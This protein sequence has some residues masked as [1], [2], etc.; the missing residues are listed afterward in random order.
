MPLSQQNFQPS[1]GTSKSVSDPRSLDEL[2][3]FMEKTIED[4]DK[5]REE[6]KEQNKK[7]VELEEQNKKVVEEVQALKKAIEDDKLFRSCQQA[8]F[9]RYVDICT[10]QIN[11]IKKAADEM[12]KAKEK[13]VYYL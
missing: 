5:L 11:N 13:L 2:T 10:D 1:Q 6:F 7:V 4:N 9:K 8:E 3:K 12:E